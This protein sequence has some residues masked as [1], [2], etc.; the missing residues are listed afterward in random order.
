MRFMAI[1]TVEQQD[2]QAVKRVRSGLMSQRKAK[3]NQLRGL[4]SEYG[5][6]RRKNGGT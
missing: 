6:W 5:W 1:K 2:I 3:A 4:A